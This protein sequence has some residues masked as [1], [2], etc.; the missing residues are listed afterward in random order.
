M[1]LTMIDE[2]GLDVEN[3]VEDLARNGQ[4]G[5]MLSFESSFDSEDY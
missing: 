4:D 1:A 5:E 3:Y 2:K